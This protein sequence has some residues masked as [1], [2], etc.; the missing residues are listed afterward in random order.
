MVVPFNPQGLLFVI[1]SYIYIVECYY[2][3]LSVLLYFFEELYV[4]V[5]FVFVNTL[6]QKNDYSQHAV[7]S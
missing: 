1:H 3:Y 7:C 5:D 6:V 2:Y 4:Y